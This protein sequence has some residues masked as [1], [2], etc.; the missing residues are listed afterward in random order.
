MKSK[1]LL[2]LSVTMLLGVGA[3]VG[4]DDQGDVSSNGNE[5]TSESSSSLPE[6]EPV[7][8]TDPNDTRAFNIYFDQALTEMNGNLEI[9]Q[10]KRFLLWQHVA[11][12]GGTYVVE[13]T[14]GNVSIDQ[15]VVVAEGY[16]AFKLK[17]TATSENGKNKRTKSLSG[18]VVSEE[19][20]EFNR[21]WAEASKGNYTAS[22]EM[23]GETRHGDNF[24]EMLKG[25]DKDTGAKVYE[26]TVYDES[27]AHWY[28]YTYSEANATQITIG[29][30]Y[31]YNHEILGTAPGFEVKGTDFVEI[32]DKDNNPT[33]EFHLEDSIDQDGDSTKIGPV[34]DNMFTNLGSAY[35]LLVR[36]NVDGVTAALNDEGG[37][38][39]IP[40]R[41]KGANKYLTFNYGNESFAT[42]A[43]IYDIG[44]TANAGV[45]AWLASPAYAEQIDVSALK[46][47]FN[48]MDEAKNYSVLRQGFWM[49]PNTGLAIDTPK[50]I[51]NIDGQGHTIGSYVALDTVVDDTIVNIVLDAD[52]NTVTFADTLI[53]GWTMPE[54]NSA[55]A[56]YVKNGTLNVAQ[57]TVTPPE[58]EEGEATITY[59]APTDTGTAV[60]TLWGKDFLNDGFAEILDTVSFYKA[61]NADGKSLYAFNTR[62]DDAA[63]PF[64][65]GG[66]VLATFV[67]GA[68]IGGLHDYVSYVSL[69]MLDFNVN[70]IWDVLFDRAG[71]ENY[72]TSYF[73]L[74]EG[75]LS[76]VRILD[77]SNDASYYQETTWTDVGTTVLDD[78]TLALLA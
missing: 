36:N 8:S 35:H 39:L 57:G 64:G 38:D 67:S 46:G 53:K 45:T 22:S 43:S 52:A 77:F 12:P 30:G 62:G 40:T 18:N 70:M 73:V 13:V 78:A 55:T 71:K 19:K 49:D 61:I 23:H 76:M 54:A 41:N 66:Y 58:T 14:S 50:D 29:Q 1:K 15:H 56:Y 42:T 2:L 28:P 26:G 65:E 63:K 9:A 32:F 10:G 59:D 3:L 5:T 74:T 6:D 48:A 27:S 20:V 75:A 34:I 68:I 33:G 17:I 24:I 11:V 69:D 31:G 60:D 4:C 7:E 51:N 44:S 37:F 72:F 16:G 47:F 25:T 21:L